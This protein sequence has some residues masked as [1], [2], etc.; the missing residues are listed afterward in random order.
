VSFFFLT[1]SFS[2]NFH[3]ILNC[4]IQLLQLLRNLTELQ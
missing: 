3:K 4:G 1:K 2:G